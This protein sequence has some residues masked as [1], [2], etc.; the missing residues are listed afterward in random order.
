[1][2][3]DAEALAPGSVVVKGNIIKFDAP[4]YIKGGKTIV[5]IRAI[6][7]ELGAEVVWD[8]NTQ[9]VTVTKDGVVVV[10]TMGSSTATVNG[11]ETDMG[12][13]A[14]ANCGRSFIPLRFLAETF[15]LEVDWDGENELIDIDDGTT[16]PEDGE[17]EVP[18]DGTEVP[19]GETAE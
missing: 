2:Y 3:A 6:T 10:I 11:V 15:G 5:P 16:E 7:E 8:E 1:M 9:S 19:V 12:A 18:D 17:A 14:A 13:S 4:P